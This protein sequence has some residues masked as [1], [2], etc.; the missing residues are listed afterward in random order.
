MPKTVVLLQG[1]WIWVSEDLLGLQKDVKVRP[2]S[3]VTCSILDQLEVL[4]PPGHPEAP[5]SS[6]A[7]LV[8]SPHSDSSLFIDSKLSFLMFAVLFSASQRP[9]LVSLL[10]DEASGSC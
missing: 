5:G 6:P 7:G 2:G 4:R 3:H 1:R 10:K 9:L 8:S